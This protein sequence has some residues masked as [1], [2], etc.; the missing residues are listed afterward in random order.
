MHASVTS[1]R[2]DQE[3]DDDVGSE[4]Q[5]HLDEDA[6]Q[7]EPFASDDFVAGDKFKQEVA[8]NGHET[9]EEPVSGVGE[10]QNKEKERERNSNSAPE[11]MIV[12]NS[13]GVSPLAFLS[14][15]AG[16]S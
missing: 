9:N 12:P 13:E 2:Q 11:I 3:K 14:I 6:L 4:K 10:K 7:L 8:E 1:K 15:K 5:L 16:N